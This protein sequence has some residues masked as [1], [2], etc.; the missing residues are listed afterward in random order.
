MK[1]KPKKCVSLAFRQ[2][3]K[4]DKSKFTPRKP[5]AYSAFDPKL[6][7]AGKEI[8][9]IFNP[10]EVD[11]FRREHF[12]FLGRWIH[13]NLT[14]AK[15][16]EN[17]KTEV[18]RL[19]ATTKKAHLTGFMKLWLYQHYILAMLV[20]PFLI[21]DLDLSF[22]SSLEKHA[23]P[24]LKKWAGLFAKADTGTLYRPKQTF[25]LGLTS[26]CTHFKKMQTLKCHLLSNSPDE[27]VKAV[28]EQK[29]ANEKAASRVWRPT[30]L[31]TKA[32]AMATHQ[33][34]FPSQRGRRGLGHG[35]FCANPSAID[36]RKQ[37]SSAVSELESERHLTH[38][39]GL[40]LQG[41]WTKWW[42]KA[43]PFDLSW[44]NLIYGTSANVVSFV[45]NAT[46]NSVVTPD[47]LSL[48]KCKEDPSCP[49]CGK[50]QCTL[51]HILSGCKKA[52]S[53]KR[54]TWR[55]D[56]VLSALEPFLR[57]Q[58]SN[59]TSFHRP[60]HFVA[61]SQQP[62][63]SKRKRNLLSNSKDWKMEIDF[64]SK[65]YS[66]PEH[67]CATPLRPDVLLYSNESKRMILLELTCPMEEN[68][69]TANLEKEAKYLKLAPILER[70]WS[71]TIIPF[72]VGA[73]GFVASSTV[74]MLHNLGFS[75]TRT[76][77]ICKHLSR[78]VA[79]CS[80]TIWLNRHTRT[81]PL[82]RSLL[83][84]DC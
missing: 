41:V 56:S 7:I 35:N 60:A 69:S 78:V 59:A 51:A 72:E 8:A 16:K 32:Q 42:E 54:L 71:M 64:D 39:F 52:L 80:Y 84:L 10:Q 17:V 58:I 24:L 36:V 11:P 79:R 83:S 61:Q 50:S 26:L 33:L 12:K 4:N 25:G 23:N 30:Q 44:N 37:V 29:V 40:K 43:N 28:Y 6:T 18:E 34:R 20:W 55:H 21:H 76:K 45:L 19:F 77:K 63:K 38:A 46:I 13:E 68:L 65:H 15:I 3:S 1:A 53:D 27:D 73:R 14:E 2:F 48:W 67:I 57:K 74:K 81:W 62:P 70:N 75:T 5:T 49:L 66:F 31:T 22:V 47:M 82:A 9:F